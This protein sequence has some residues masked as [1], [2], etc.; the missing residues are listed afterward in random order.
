MRKFYR[1]LTKR[2]ITVRDGGSSRQFWRSPGSKKEVTQDHK[3]I[4]WIPTPERQG[5]GELTRTYID[6]P[7]DSGYVLA[8][9]SY[10]TGVRS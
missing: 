9:T 1:H 8:K 2:E 4:Q 3:V 7:I 6:H 10:L 5:C